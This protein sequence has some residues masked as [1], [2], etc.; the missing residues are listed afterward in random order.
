[1]QGYRFNECPETTQLW[2]LKQQHPL[3]AVRAALTYV[4]PLAMSAQNIRE[5]VPRRMRAKIHIIA[6]PMFPAA[7]MRLLQAVC[8]VDFFLANP[9]RDDAIAVAF[10]FKHAWNNL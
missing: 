1:M 8:H 5:R 10:N 2:K 6:A 9:H 7:S 4:L 3:A